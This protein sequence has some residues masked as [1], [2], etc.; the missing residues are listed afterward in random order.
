MIHTL[1]LI[2][3]TST[4]D[5]S[6][7]D[8]GGP[9]TTP[10]TIPSP[11]TTISGPAD[12]GFGAALAFSTGGVL[13]IGAPHGDP[14][15][16]YLHTEADGLSTALTGTGRLGSALAADPSST[17]IVVGAPLA[18]SFAGEARDAT[19]TILA[20]GG[21]SAGLAVGWTD[22]WIV[23]DAT[24]WQ[25]ATDRATTQARP[26]A[27]AG[28]LQDDTWL[29]GVGMAHSTDM[30]QVNKTTLP[31][32]RTNSEAGYALASGD[33]DGDGEAEWAVGAPV[34]GE[35]YI[36][37]ADA[38]TIEQTLTGTGRFGAALAA[39]DV[40]GDGI[41]DL[42]VG[43]PM[44]GREAEGAAHLFT[45]GNL[46][47]AETIWTGSA[48]GAQLGFAVAARTGEVAWS[49]PGAAGQPGVVTRSPR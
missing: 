47:S 31:A 25:S 5:P 11:N 12:A 49:A 45:R 23:A 13:W 33:F 28:L 29:I 40:D 16:L 8:T 10:E 18:D 1:L 15:T 36:V 21:Q 43:A 44:E 6:T 27:L 9:S 24:G 34:A 42:M 14:P 26:S 22:G 38:T 2:A 46:T 48:P 7:E 41:T 37:S 3:C 35:V 32:P 19:G 20:T 4:P 30:L 39:A 17:D